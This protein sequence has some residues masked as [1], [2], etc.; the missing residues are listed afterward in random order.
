MPPPPRQP[1][2]HHMLMTPSFVSAPKIWLPLK[3]KSN[4]ES[5]Q[6]LNKTKCMHFCQIH[7][8]LNHPSL[9]LNDTEI[10]ITHQHKFL[11]I[12]LDSKL[13]FIHPYQT[14]EDQMQTNYPPEIYSPH[15]LGY[16]QKDCNL[17]IQISHMN[18]AWLQLFIYEVA[19]KSY[20]WEF[21]AIHS[22]GLCIALGTFTISP[23]ESLYIEAN[24][25]TSL[26]E[27]A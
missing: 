20:L 21:D 18:K 2:D 26:L 22:Q 19:R 17:I 24:K 23:R 14:T 15:R 7:K 10:C 12:T 5:I 13:Y 9:I 1:T 8:M 4:N 3:E 25:P 6:K 11:G 16:W 27:K